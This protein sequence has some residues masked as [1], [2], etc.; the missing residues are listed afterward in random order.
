MNLKNI[1]FKLQTK[2]IFE[3]TME[4]MRKLEILNLL[5]QKEEESI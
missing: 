2:R 1:F 5:Q 4:N 3:K